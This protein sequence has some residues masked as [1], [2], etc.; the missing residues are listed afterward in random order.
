[1]VDEYQDTNFSQYNIIRKLTLQHHNICVVGDDSQSIY[2]FRGARVQ[3]I[4]N[5]QKDYPEC[6]VIR[7]ERNY[8]STQTI[9]NAANSVIEHNSSRIPKNCYS[10]ADAGEKIRILECMNE[11]EEAA[12][13]TSEV[14]IRKSVENGHYS[15]FAIL[16]RTNSQSRAIE[17]ALRRR[18]IPYMVYSG[19]S[20]YE[21]AEIKD[22]MSYLKLVANVNDDES[23]KRVV[24]KPTRGIGDT[25]VEALTKAANAHK[26]SLFKAIWL[27]D[28][29]SFDLKSA[30]QARLKDFG[31]K[32]SR[33][34]AKVLTIDA[35]VLARET[36]D[37]M[38]YLDF[39]KK[40]TS[41]EGVNKLENVNE[42]LDSIETYV[43]E[44]TDEAL[45][46]EQQPTEIA[47]PDFLENVSL[48]SN[49]DTSADGD[50]NDKV[51][52]MTV[53]SSKGLEFPYVII[54]GMETNLFPSLSMMGS[55]RDL[56]EERRLFYV[57]LTRAKKSVV[58]THCDS[59]LRNGKTETNELS[60]FVKEI[61]PKYLANPPAPSRPSFGTSY[62]RS[63]AVRYESRTPR[64]DSASRPDFAS[65]Q[66]PQSPMPKVQSPRATAVPPP[67]QLDFVP[68]KMEVFRAGQRVEHNRFGS[69][70]IISLTGE[71][72]ELRAEVEFDAYGK[73]ILL[74][75]YAK[76]R[77][78]KEH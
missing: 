13:I 29:A 75:K 10:E 57:A 18:N 70:R 62:G 15:D 50:E 53:H 21:R 5:F 67:V 25:S 1:M 55:S 43:Q 3:N 54:A 48:L 76:M 12:R 4:L 8:R 39:L 2:A 60:M 73:K 72:P 78:E 71:I 42:L 26:T 41:Q 68:D 28:L 20:F 66:K 19:N 17:D 74:L 40:D 45:E 27:D 63:S 24:N 23:F 33:L 6:K 37:D 52:L 14:S 36:A 11:I 61:D 46:N 77:V 59:R 34:S 58:I 9:V 47:L 51:A 7:L 49:A 56:E 65:R 16:Y 22:M 69:G 35:N 64:H 31:E 30:A 32:I 38:G 44:R